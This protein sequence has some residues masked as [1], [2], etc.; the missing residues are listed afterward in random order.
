MADKW[1]LAN[2]N[3]SN[4]ANWNGGTKPVAGDDVYADGRTVTVDE[5]F[6]VATIRNTQRSGGTAGGSFS[7]NSG[8]NCTCSII[9]GSTTCVT[10]VSGSVTIN[11]NV[12]GGTGT[13]AAGISLTNNGVIL[14]INGNL[15]GG[16]GALSGNNNSAEVPISM[17]SV[18][19]NS[20]LIL[21]GNVT[22]GG[23]VG[24]F[25]VCI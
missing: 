17:G 2:G 9:T 6:N 8:R 10:G 23:G 12:T 11:G 24:R 1:P 18:G 5:D 7:F 3:W 20:K 13:P 4:A 22:G 15:I 25:C 19:G 16:S 21:D 14:T